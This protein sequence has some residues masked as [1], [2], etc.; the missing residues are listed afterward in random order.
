MKLND[1]AQMLFLLIVLHQK[2]KKD[3]EMKKEPCFGAPSGVWAYLLTLSLRTTPFS[4]FKDYFCFSHVLATSSSFQKNGQGLLDSALNFKKSKPQFCV[5]SVL[6]CCCAANQYS[7][8]GRIF[9]NLLENSA[10]SK[11]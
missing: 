4:G 11:G 8:I 6:V 1:L 2:V 5:I 3:P 9:K 7:E 10:R